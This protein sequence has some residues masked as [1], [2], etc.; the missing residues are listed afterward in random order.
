[1]VSAMKSK[2]KIKKALYDILDQFERERPQ[3]IHAFW[4]CIFNKIIMDQYSTLRQLHNSIMDG[5]TQ[6]V[7]VIISEIRIVIVLVVLMVIFMFSKVR[8]K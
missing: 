1:M 2:E 3:D 4:R 8:D 5:K 7:M 6:F